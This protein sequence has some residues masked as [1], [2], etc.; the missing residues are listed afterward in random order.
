MLN[1]AQIIFLIVAIIFLSTLWVLSNSSTVEDI[2]VT[3]E[4]LV[5]K[6]LIPNPIS[7]PYTIY[8]KALG[9]YKCEKFTVTGGVGGQ[10]IKLSN[11]VVAGNVRNRDATIQEVKIPYNGIDGIFFNFKKMEK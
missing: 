6:N 5:A 1:K 3:E 10:W 8:T 2:V 11:C 7:R 9:I 4:E